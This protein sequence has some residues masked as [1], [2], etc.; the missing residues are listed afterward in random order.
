MDFGI[1]FILLL[2]SI[3]VEAYRNAT[4]QEF[5]NYYMQRI[6]DDLPPLEQI[7]D[8]NK[9]PRI[10]IPVCATDNKTYTNVC[11]MNCM[12]L[13]TK[14]DEYDYVRVQYV[15]LCLQFLEPYEY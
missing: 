10:Y 14:Q 15:G 12:N 13:I 1:T 5:Q 8:C 3:T 4:A 2:A 11:W 9:C 6:E 7:F